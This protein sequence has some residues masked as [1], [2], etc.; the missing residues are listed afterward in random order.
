LSLAGGH[1]AA[2]ITA[3]QRGLQHD[4][5]ASAVAVTPAA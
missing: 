2:S 1:G 4:G 3:A 5:I